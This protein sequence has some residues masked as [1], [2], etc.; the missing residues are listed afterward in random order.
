MVDD[1]LAFG[2]QDSCA[3]P[4][5]SNTRWADLGSYALRRCTKKS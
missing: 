2:T 3:N 1:H 5:Q 4:G